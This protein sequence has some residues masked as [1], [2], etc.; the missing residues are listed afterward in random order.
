MAV[1]SRAR[2][3]CCFL[4]PIYGV[5]AF[6]YIWIL[7]GMIFAITGW[8]QVIQLKFYPIPTSYEVALYF[9]ALVFTFMT[10]L[11]IYGVVATSMRRPSLIMGL[12]IL[13]GIHFLMSI[14]A[15]S[16]LLVMIHR[17]RTDAQ[18]ISCLDQAYNEMS[19]QLCFTP[20]TMPQNVAVTIYVLTWVLELYAAFIA[21][22]FLQDLKQR[23]ANKDVEGKPRTITPDIISEPTLIPNYKPATMSMGPDGYPISIIDGFG[24][25]PQV[26]GYGD[27][28]QHTWDQVPLSRPPGISP[29]T[30]P[31]TPSRSDYLTGIRPLRLAPKNSESV[32]QPNSS[33]V[34]PPIEVSTSPIHPYGLGSAGISTSYAF[35]ADNNSFGSR[36]NTPTQAAYTSFSS[37]GAESNRF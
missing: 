16:Y 6:S 13:I 15:G 7:G 8:S 3:C 31:L 22:S 34:I 1:T 24:E 37:A 11:G 23:A 17:V 27:V 18:I 35:S 28:E 2:Q 19:A 21:F 25:M 14:I 33:I 26:Q 9:Q 32:S 36:A 30:T 10:L 12:F 29:P 4:A 20:I 5:L